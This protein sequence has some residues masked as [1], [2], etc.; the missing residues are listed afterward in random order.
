MPQTRARI[1]D[2]FA[3]LMTNAAGVA[4]GV[5]REA[6]TAVKTQAERLLAA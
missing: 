6:E 1:F 2:D 5:R 4:N 3:R